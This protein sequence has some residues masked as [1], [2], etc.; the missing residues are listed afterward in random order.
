MSD[1][2]EPKKETVRITLPP[3]APSKIGEPGAE[4]RE[5]VRINLPPKSLPNGAPIEPPKRATPLL[6]KPPT[7]PVKAPPMGRPPMPQPSGGPVRPPP[8]GAMP[9][10]PPA[11]IAEM[12]APA[13]AEPPQPSAMM[14]R[15]PAPSPPAPARPPMPPPPLVRPAAVPTSSSPEPAKTPT[16]APPPPLVMPPRPRVLPPAPRVIPPPAPPGAVTSAPANYPGSSAQ[17]GPKKETARISIL[18]EPAAPPPATV[19]MAKTQPLMT[20]PA[21]K[22]QSVPVTV[23]K[24]PLVNVSQESLGEMFAL[25]DSVPL[26]I[27]WTI[28]AV[29]SVTLLIQIWNYLAS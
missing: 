7:V 18:P 23:A 3:R 8:P 14:P 10:R 2:N 13:M 19:K 17:A 28:F 9:P 15:P 6:P 29:S 11:P 12:N 26:P 16:P 24:T 22:M 5:A 4:D 20:T 21:A 27:C 25:L 1:P